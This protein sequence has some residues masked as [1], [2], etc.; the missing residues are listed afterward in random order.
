MDRK[1]RIAF[2]QPVHPTG[3]KVYYLP[4]ASGVLWAYASTDQEVR[5][6][7]E[8]VDFIF[9]HE[10]LDQLIPKLADCDV[11]AFSTYV[12]NHR[13]N[14]N[15]AS[16]LKEVNPNIVTI[17]GGPEISISDPDLFKKE[18]FM[19]I[20]VVQEG[21]VA[22]TQILKN[23]DS[24]DFS[25]IPGLLINDNGT[26]IDTGKPLRINELDIV[27]SPYLTGVFDDLI[28]NNPT[29][30]WN[31]IIET[32]RGC[33]Y[34]CTFCDW[35]SLTYSKVKKFPLE[36]IC[37]ELDWVAKNKILFITFPDANFGIFPERDHLI[38]DKIVEVKKATQYPSN[39]WVQ[40]AKNSNS[41]IVEIFKK[42]ANAGLVNQKFIVSVQSLTPQV[43]HHIR[44]KNLAV[45]KLEELFKLC[46]D[47]DLNMYTELILG[48]PGETLETWK[49]NFYTLYR[50][51]NHTGIKF[52]YAQLLENAEL[53]LSQKKLFDIET[54]SVKD[55]FAKP[56]NTQQELIDVVISTKDMP[57]ED[58]YSA[59]VFS[60]FQLTWHINNLSTLV[61]RF[62]NRYLNIDYPEFYDTLK[63]YVI[64]NSDWFKHEEDELIYYHEKWL[65]DGEI[66]CPIPYVSG[67]MLATKTSSR[68]INGES[69]D[70]VTRLLKNFVDQYDIPDDLKRDLLELQTKYMEKFY[71]HG[72]DLIEVNLS[73]NLYDYILGRSE[74]IQEDTLY[75]IDFPENKQF[76]KDNKRYIYIQG[77]AFGRQQIK[78]QD[79]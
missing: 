5:E 52:Y 48:L 42:L 50:S 60:W 12:W 73:Y 28:H 2:V 61:A 15:L 64:S 33:P 36:R 17:F 56:S 3:R 11:V 30:E 9:K 55:F 47:N 6:K 79:K 45:N 49:E 58:M 1:K 44:R 70:E 19:D 13:Y 16:K 40:W 72:T 78:R 20:V 27:P 35:G 67:P 37:D 59:I 54:K 62:M 57:L 77:N 26:V 23:Y 29:V 8:L 53:N 68:F 43:L 22:L 18:P 32:T 4:Y 10:P 31:V 69:L 34:Q 51:G 24:K 63:K 14:Y 71:R 25:A 21:E 76:N 74:L 66:D 41:Q 65:S 75:Y 46:E 39:L 7:F 38:A